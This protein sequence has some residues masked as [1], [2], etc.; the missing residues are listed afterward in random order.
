MKSTAG[1]SIVT[2]RGV[3]QLHV[4]N[5]AGGKRLKEQLLSDRVI[6]WNLWLNVSGSREW[7]GN[8]CLP[9]FANRTYCHRLEHI[10]I[11]GTGKPT[12]SLMIVNYTERTK[13]VIMTSVTPA[14]VWGEAIAWAIV[15][16]YQAKPHNPGAFAFKHM[17]WYRSLSSLSW[18]F[19]TS[20][21]GE[22]L[23]MM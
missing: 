19:D 1:M 13:A 9:S 11:L 4:R 8:V 10:T 14:G 22:V 5:Q 20:F 16:Y 18:Q 7:L 21:E 2:S 23:I 6:D 12:T 3:L 15:F 17:V